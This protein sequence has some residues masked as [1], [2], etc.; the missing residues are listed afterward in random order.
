VSEEK[1]GDDSNQ[2]LEV[3]FSGLEEALGRRNEE[4]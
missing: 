2:R 3:H 1:E 4:E